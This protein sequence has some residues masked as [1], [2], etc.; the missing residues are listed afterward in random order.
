MST[1]RAVLCA[2]L[3]YVL[4]PAAA[5]ADTPSRA[6]V[7]KA[8]AAGNYAVCATLYSQIADAANNGDDGYNAACCYA[9]A[10]DKDAAFERLNKTISAGFVGVS[11]IEQDEDFNSLHDDSR[12]M[13]L[14]AF[15]RQEADRHLAGVDRDLR[16]ELGE[17]VD[18]DQAI[19]NRW[20]ADPQNKALGEEAVR[21]YADNTA[22]MKQ[23][24][25]THGWPGYK[26]VYMDGEDDAWLLVQHADQDPEFQQQALALLEKAVMEKDADPKHLAYLTDRVRTH[27][28][29][30]QLYGTQLTGE[31]D[32]M[33][34]FPIE[35]EAHVDERR[36][37]IG[38]G[39]LADYIEQA[40]VIYSH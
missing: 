21:I 11:Q 1:F 18:R 4:L 27:R 40:R 22:W 26:L 7:D 10:G 25:A 37:R 32:K 23:V 19:L 34:P 3:S 8:L 28:G 35:D 9:L 2:A 31:G 24:I 33:V 20:M 12:W 5:L 30:K 6:V 17:R 36:Q 13:P 16:R 29:E 39:P 15:A 14:L 38:L